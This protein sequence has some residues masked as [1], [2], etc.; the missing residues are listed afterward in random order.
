M[1]IR[2]GVAS[3]LLQTEVE[4]RAARALAGSATVRDTVI[5]RE[6]IAEQ[7]SAMVR[8]RVDAVPKIIGT[9]HRRVPEVEIQRGERQ[10]D[11]CPIG[12][13]DLH[14]SRR[15]ACSKDGCEPLS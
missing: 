2:I 1:E 13:G 11:G 4:T 7:V 15:T 9:L 6:L 8:R 14:R 3:P 5:D 10:P 12:T